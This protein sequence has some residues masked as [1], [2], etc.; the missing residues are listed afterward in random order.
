MGEHGEEVVAAAMGVE[1]VVAGAPEAVRKPAG[2]G[3]DV[4]PLH[5]QA[6][7]LDAEFCGAVADD[8]AGLAD[9][10]DVMSALVQA[11][12]EEEGLLDLSG[13]FSLFLDLHDAHHQLRSV[14]R[15][16]NFGS[17]MRLP[18][19]RRG[20]RRGSAPGRTAPLTVVQAVA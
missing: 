10:E 19:V 4:Q 2:G 15:S 9:D 1:D 8:G 18:M 12:G 14:I 3:E 20:R 5:G 16:R 6:H 13:P 7:D 17:L 11:F